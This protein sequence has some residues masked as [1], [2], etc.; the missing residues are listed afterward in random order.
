M[1][2]LLAQYIDVLNSPPQKGRQKEQ[3]VQDF[4]ETNSELFY[5][6]GLLGHQ[7]HFET[8]LSKFPL[9]T[10]L[11]TDFIYLT[12]N[13][14][15][16][17]IYLVELESP[18]KKLFV[19]DDKSVKPTADL[20][21]AIAQMQDWK[22]FLNRDKE[23]FLRQI[24]PLRVPLSSNAVEFKYYLIIGRRD[25]KSEYENR[26]QRLKTISDDSQILIRTYDSLIEPFKNGQKIKKNILKLSK[27]SFEMKRIN[28]PPQSMLSYLT[29]EYLLLSKE[30]KK[31]LTDLGYEIDKWEK[32]KLLTLNGKKVP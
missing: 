7:L 13:S 5:T 27:N 9:S 28:T 14:D 21:A 19:K 15:F 25:D 23:S 12:K 8:L 20:T 32:G 3:E 31:Y 1:T 2:D 6:P 10:G 4:L 17:H 22:E 26:K 30:Q 18:T 29:P 24:K 16:W 11:I